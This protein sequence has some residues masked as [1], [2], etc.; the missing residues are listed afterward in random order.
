VDRRQFLSA[1]SAL[2]S[3]GVIASTTEGRHQVTPAFLTCTTDIHFVAEDGAPKVG[4]VAIGSAGGWIISQLNG[5][6]PRL[7]RSVAVNADS[8]LLQRTSADRRIVVGNGSFLTIESTEAVPLAE[9]ASAEIA[10]AIDGVDLLYI[11]TDFG[12]SIDKALALVASK[13]A[14]SNQVTAIGAVIESLGP[15]GVDTY[16][17]IPRA[18]DLL[19]QQGVQM[20]SLTG[21]RASRLRFA[22]S[23]RG[24]PMLMEA[25]TTF[26]RLYRSTVV[27]Q[28]G[29]QSLVSLDGED[30][31]SVFSQ[32]G[33]SRM[34]IGYGSAS[35]PDASQLA[36]FKAIAHQGFDAD[37]EQSDIE[38]LVSME[39]RPGCL[40]FR[41]VNRA[42]G[43]IRDAFPFCTLI[44]GAFRNPV[45]DD[46]FSVTVV[47]PE[48]LPRLQVASA[49]KGTLGALK[50]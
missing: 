16:Q 24:T 15:S 14:H 50:K 37:W 28:G 43:V 34:V 12:Q 6:L 41:E 13:I 4:I 8:F 49:Q 20:I 30:V 2:G 35:G 32:K 40:K 36:A 17:A 45:L 9:A 5:K 1:V 7:F 31:R 21:G 11:L 44:F 29:D 25:A 48:T 26:E 47:A 33:Y 46:D 22:P 27:T 42:I 19:T 38:F 18:I 39:A 3:S 10:A 23:L